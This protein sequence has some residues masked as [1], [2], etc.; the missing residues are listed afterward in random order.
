MLKFVTVIIA[1]ATLVPTALAE[2]LV[3]KVTKD[4]TEFRILGSIHVGSDA[5]YPLPNE[6]EN[7][8]ANSQ[9]L[10]VEADLSQLNQVTYPPQ[11]YVSQQVLTDVQ[12]GQA[13]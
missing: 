10:I 11:R 8:I 3:W 5:L 6:I 7:A 2:P 1:I 9:A 12:S 4:K 13:P